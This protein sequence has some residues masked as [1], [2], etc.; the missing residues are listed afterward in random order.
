MVVRGSIGALVG[1]AAYGA[2]RLAGNRSNASHFLSTAVRELRP[3]GAENRKFMPKSFDT[4]KL[5]PKGFDPKKVVDSLDLND[6]MRKL[7]D[8]AE[9]IEARSEDVRMISGQAKRLSRKLS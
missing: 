6:L 8:A 3:K 2:T 7:G 9:Q 5:V 4:S 1:G